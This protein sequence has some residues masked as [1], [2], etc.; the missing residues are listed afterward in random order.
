MCLPRV[1]AHRDVAPT[2]TPIAADTTIVSAASSSMTGNRRP[3]SSRIGWQVQ[4]ERPKS[5]RVTIPPIHSR[6]W[7]YTGRSR[8]RSCRSAGSV[9]A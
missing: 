8:P 3:N 9:G 2:A 4:Y 5:P 1:L 7:T 6:Y